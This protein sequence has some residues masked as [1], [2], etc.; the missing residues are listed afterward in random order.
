MKLFSLPFTP[1]AS[2]SFP[3]PLPNTP[4][5]SSAAAATTTSTTMC[6]GAIEAY[7]TC[8]IMFE[9]KTLKVSKLLQYMAWFIKIEN[10]I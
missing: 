3:L 10:Y 9:K 4:S 6:V 5:T 2:V 8:N 1:K 7:L